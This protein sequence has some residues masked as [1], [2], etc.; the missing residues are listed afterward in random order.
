MELLPLTNP[1]EKKTLLHLIG[2][3][4]R[5]GTNLI[6]YISQIIHAYNNHYFIIYQNVNYNES[7]FVKALIDF[8]DAYN[9]Q[10]YETY[11]YLQDTEEITICNKDDL[12]Y[13]TSLTV[14][15]LKCDLIS[16][17][18]KHIYSHMKTHLEKY[19]FNNPEYN[20]IPFDPKKTILVHL[21]LEDVR[22]WPNYD[23]RICCSHY[24]RL[25]NMGERCEWSCFGWRYNR[26]TPLPVENVQQQIDYALDRHPEHEVIIITSPGDYDTGFSYRSIRSNNENTDLFLL[27]NS[28]VVILS[29]SNFALSSLFFGIA[30]DVYVPM[31]GHL[32]CL[33]PCTNYDNSNF[34]YF[35]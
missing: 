5:L 32:S 27:C 31:W 12:N 11:N 34:N 16:Y 33:G 24:S 2:R 14:M 22:T 23:G 3:C 29:R 18:K 13:T 8:V 15:H 6:N 9:N 19:T 7:I 10:L 26:Q 35:Y 25:I 4:D 28:E 20:N 30:T 17:F 21:R 1:P